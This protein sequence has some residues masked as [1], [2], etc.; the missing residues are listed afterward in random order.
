VTPLIANIRPAGKYLME[1]FYYAGGLPAVH[2]QLADLL[3]LDA[4]TVTGRTLG[5]A[6]AGATIVNDDVIRPRDQPLHTG[7]S[8]AILHGNLCPD[9]AVLKVSAASD[10]LLQHEGRAVVFD[11]VDELHATIDDP[12]LEI[13]PDDVLVLRNA[14]PVGAPGMPEVGHLPMPSYLLRQGVRDMVRISDARMSG[15]GFGTVI[16]H[17]APEAAVGGALALVRTGDRIRLDTS[18]RSLDVLVDPAELEAR[19]RAWE[20]RPMADVRGYRG[21]YVR[22]V[23]Q[24]DRGCDLDF[25]VGS[26]AAVRAGITHG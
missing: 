3:H 25:L 23:M 16:L 1:D 21:L 7:G 4:R 9:G 12:A 13:E 26:S 8:L 10:R 17:V 15:T 24:A 22:T 5:E 11:G 19:R 2:A 14:G 6:I 20:P 18:G